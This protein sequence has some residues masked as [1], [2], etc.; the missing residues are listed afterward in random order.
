[1]SKTYFIICSGFFQIN[2]AQRVLDS[3]TRVNNWLGRKLADVT[4]YCEINH[5]DS[6]SLNIFVDY[7]EQLSTFLNPINLSS[8]EASSYIL[9]YVYN[10]I[11]IEKLK[12][13]IKNVQNCLDIEDRLDSE[14][15]AQLL[16]RILN[17]HAMK[18]LQG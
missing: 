9:K 13:L 1:M 10:P 5:D 4:H 6:L 12:S 7:H 8:T 3:K 15:L 2:F 16:N 17:V 14:A 11:L 18:V